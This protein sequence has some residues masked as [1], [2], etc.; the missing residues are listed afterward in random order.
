MSVSAHEDLVAQKEGLEDEID[1]LN[2]EE[3]RA[4]IKHVMRSISEKGRLAVVVGHT[5]LAPGAY[6]K[7][8]IDE[9]EYAFN[10]RIALRMA[11]IAKEQATQVGVF[12]RDGVGIAGAYKQ[13]DVFKPD[14][15]IELHFNAA[16]NIAATGTEALFGTR[17]QGSKVLAEIVQTHMLATLQLKTRA[18]LERKLG[19]K[20][21]G[22]QSVNA[23]AA[24]TVLVEPFFG[25]NS[26]DCQA[27]SRL[28]EAYAQCL[29][30]AFS[31][32]HASLKAAS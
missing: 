2:P 22:A 26:S 23:A 1:K 12:Y 18:L 20:E 11:E 25:S 5:R 29:V 8:P 31:V 17:T 9:H 21:R 28:T 24:P 13:V 3:A 6:G 27:I 15:A 32:F 10:S 7:Q 19:S 14:A 30:V 4:P 16:E